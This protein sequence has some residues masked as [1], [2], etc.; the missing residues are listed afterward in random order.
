MVLYKTLVIAFTQNFN[1]EKWSFFFLV[2]AYFSYA[3]PMKRYLYDVELIY[4]AHIRKSK[5]NL[6]LEV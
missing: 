4:D 1:R 5:L 3:D 2:A 6:S